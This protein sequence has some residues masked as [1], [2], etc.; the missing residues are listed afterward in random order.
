MGRGSAHKPQLL[1]ICLVFNRLN[2]VF[3]IDLNLQFLPT[4]NCNFY[5]LKIAKN[6]FLRDFKQPQPNPITRFNPTL[7]TIVVAGGDAVLSF[8]DGIYLN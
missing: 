8:G 3:C 2:T 5:L 4:K 7:D 1:S 6:Q